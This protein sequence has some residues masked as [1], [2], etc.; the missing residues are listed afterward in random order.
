VSANDEAPWIALI[1]DRIPGHEPQDTIEPSLEHAAGRRGLPSPE[2]R[3][4]P[5]E[6]IEELGPSV[7]DGAS[8]VWCT[9]G[10]PYRS[11]SGALTGIRAARERGVPFI[12]TCAGFQHAVIEFA[13]N[14]LGQAEASHAEYGDEGVLFIDEL[15]CSIVGRQ[16]E[17]E[18]VDDLV[19]GCYGRRTALERYYCRFGLNPEF[20]PLLHEAGL[21][22][23]GVDA[24]DDEVRIM[25]VADHPWFVVTLFVPQVLSDPGAPHPL[26]TAFLDAT[27]AFAASA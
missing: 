12:G 3:W 20:R 16:M 6:Q 9:P 15:R 13:R 5:T 26:I 11:M 23:A 24:A 10:S 17:V 7:L 18:L 25:R 22:V 1:G 14:V 19:A 27:V 2:V 21:L 8:G 4:L